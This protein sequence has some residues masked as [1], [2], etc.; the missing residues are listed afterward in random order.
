M[1][2]KSV[3]DDI[4]NIITSNSNKISYFVKWFV[5]SDR[6]EESYN[7]NCKK[8]TT[9]EFETAM[10]DWLNREDVQEAIKQ[11]LKSIR[12]LKML[13]IYNSM[14]GKAIEGDKNCADWC[15]KFFKSDFFESVEDE[16]NKY[17][18]GIN[19]PGLSG[20]K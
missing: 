3:N 9:V 14:Y 20:D 16:A 17:L 5:D 10:N 1:A 4:K 6:T 13:D 2:K 11:Y 12:S 8:N 19:I 15:E 18:E 7:K